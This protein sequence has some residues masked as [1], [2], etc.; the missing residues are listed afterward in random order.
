M[1]VGG[2]LGDIWPP[3]TRGIAIVGYAMA[4]VGGPVLGPIVGGAIV[5]S[6]LRWRWT[7]YVS[8][9]SMNSWHPIHLL[10][11][12]AHRNHDDVHPTT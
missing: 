7:E 8:Y 11:T 2:V 9:L 4:V 6:Y 1:C 3:E 12:V 5:Q 10:T